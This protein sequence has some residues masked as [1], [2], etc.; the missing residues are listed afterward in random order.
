MLVEHTVRLI[1]SVAVAA[2]KETVGEHV[3]SWI[4]RERCAVGH[5]CAVNIQGRAVGRIRQREEMEII[6]RPRNWRGK[7]CRVAAGIVV[8]LRGEIKVVAA[9]INVDA[10][11]AII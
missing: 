2:K 6:R 5:E 10:P 7:K 3:C 11:P 1:N 9:V 8:G 4:Y